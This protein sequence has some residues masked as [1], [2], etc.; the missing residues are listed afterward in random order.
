MSRKPAPLVGKFWKNTKA[1]KE[2]E[3]L[4][5]GWCCGYCLEIPTVKR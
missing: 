5:G 3:V 2:T 4:L 1:H